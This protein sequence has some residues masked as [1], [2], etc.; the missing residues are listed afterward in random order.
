MDPQVFAILP[1]K[2]VRSIPG[3]DVIYTPKNPEDCHGSIIGLTGNSLAD[4]LFQQ[5]LTKL[6]NSGKI[7]DRRD[8]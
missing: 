3:L 5:R 2:K 7:I 8:K 6:A 1:V 4:Y